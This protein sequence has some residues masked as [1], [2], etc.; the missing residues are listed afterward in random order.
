MRAK[1]EY[2][3]VFWFVK[4]NWFVKLIVSLQMYSR[5]APEH[6]QDRFVGPV[7]NLRD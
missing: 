2:I 7:L 3:L 5:L 4:I 6:L 1:W